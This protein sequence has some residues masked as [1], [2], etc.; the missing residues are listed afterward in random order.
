[1]LDAFATASG[2]VIDF[3]KSTFVLIKTDEHS[4][5][6][7]ATTFGC[8]VSSFPRTYLFLPLSTHKL[9][10]VDFA[11]KMAKSDMRLSGWRG[12]CLPIVGS[13]LLLNSV[14]T[15]MLAHAMSVGL[16]PAGVVEA[17]DKRC[18]PFLWTGEEACD[19]GQCK[20]AWPDVCIPKKFGGLGVLSLSTQN[21]ALLAK[22]LTK[23]HS[24]SA[25]PWA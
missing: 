2:L 20:V 3:H 22:F 23:I 1:M 4:A 14:L 9:R 16:L 7:M 12:S 24:N 5:L 21:D 17:I 8:A 13:L 19:G 15:A 18:R 11:P 6:S 10:I 25:A